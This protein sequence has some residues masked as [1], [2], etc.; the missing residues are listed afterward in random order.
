MQRVNGVACL[1]CVPTPVPVLL[2][3]VTQPVDE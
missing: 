2:G 1:Q 3:C